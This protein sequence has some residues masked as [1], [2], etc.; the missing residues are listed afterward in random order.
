MCGVRMPIPT[1]YIGNKV[2][3]IVAE[4]APGVPGRSDAGDDRF[5]PI[6]LRGGE[7]PTEAVSYLEAER[8]LFR[9]GR[10][11]HRDEMAEDHAGDVAGRMDIGIGC[12]CPRALRRP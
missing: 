9:A 11:I 6:V 8:V 5:N 4:N 2:V 12:G 10:R 7:R 3:A 1:C